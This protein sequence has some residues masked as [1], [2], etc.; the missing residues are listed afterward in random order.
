MA[1]EEFFTA[2]R[3]QVDELYQASAAARWCVPIEEFAQAAWKG[4]AAAAES[5]PA[6]IPK[7]LSALRS[8]DLALALGCARGNEEAWNTFCAKFRAILY[9]AALAIAHQEVEARELADSLLAELY[10]LDTSSPARSSRFAY[11]HGRSS[12]KTWLRA[13]LHQ[14]YVDE[15][16][17]SSRLVQLPEDPPET[18]EAETPVSEDEDRRYAECLGEAVEATLKEIPADEKLLLGYYYVQELTLKQIGRLTSEHEATISRHLEALRKK[19]RKRIE[20]HLRNVKKLSAFELDRCLDFASRG[21]IM[22]MERAL[23]PK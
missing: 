22:N 9:E 6:E 5:E 13:V 19:L 23:K 11:F 2:N 20:A 12:L 17:R 3:R 18:A 7:L 14:R 15:Y 1:F 4:V 10:G 16:R 8:E 21:V